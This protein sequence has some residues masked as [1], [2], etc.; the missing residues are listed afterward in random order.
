MFNAKIATGKFKMILNGEVN[1]VIELQHLKSFL[2]IFLI[3]RP[4]SALFELDIDCVDSDKLID[5]LKKVLLSSH[6]SFHST[7]IVNTNTNEMNPDIKSEL[8]K[9]FRKFKSLVSVR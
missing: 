4:V 8:I 7:L 5:T 9:L 2:N 3:K 6:G 1:K